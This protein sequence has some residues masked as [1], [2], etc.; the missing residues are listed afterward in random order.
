MPRLR[1]EVLRRRLPLPALRAAYQFALTQ[2]FQ[3]IGAEEVQ[4]LASQQAT[5]TVPADAGDPCVQ[6]PI[7]VVAGQDDGQLIPRQEPVE[8]PDHQPNPARRNV[9]Y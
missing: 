4:A 8:I 5:L 1:A 9:S 2:P 6:P 7:G 3:V